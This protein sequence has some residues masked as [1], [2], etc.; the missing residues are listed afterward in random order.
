MQALE[1]LNTALKREIEGQEYYNQ[2]ATEAGNEKGRKFFRWLAGEESGH[3]KLLNEVINTLRQHQ[4]W[5]GKQVWD[6]KHLSEPVSEEEFPS[7][8]EVMGQLPTDAP[9]LKII[10]K[11]IEAEKSDAAFYEN[12]AKQV[13]DSEGKRM[14]EKLALIESGHARAL[15]EQHKWIKYAQDV[16]ILRRFNVPTC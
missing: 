9:E 10:E 12:L 8:P 16:F 11:A 4:S 3:I 2:A 14:L 13:D 1:A 6:G 7:K 5:P 15:E